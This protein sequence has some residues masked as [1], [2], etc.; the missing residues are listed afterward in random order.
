MIDTPEG[1]VAYNI[2]RMAR[3]AWQTIRRDA[4]RLLPEFTP[5]P[6]PLHSGG[7]STYALKWQGKVR[8]GLYPWLYRGD[9]VNAGF[10]LLQ[11]GTEIVPHYGYTS[12]VLRY[13]LGLDCPENCGI[14]VDGQRYTW[15]DGESFVF[16]DTLLHSAWNRG[17]RPRLILLVDVARH[18][19]GA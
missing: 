1:A 19:K 15:R 13:H 18:K 5:W 9:V 17:D 10:S 11:P 14:E 6:E 7:W 2:D 4:E 12:D 3:P 8:H 16:D